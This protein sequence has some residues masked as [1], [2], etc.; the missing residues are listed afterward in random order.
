M[1]VDIV[2]TGIENLDVDTVTPE[3]HDVLSRLMP[4]DEEYDLY[5]KHNFD[6]GDGEKIPDEDVFMAKIC[7][8]RRLKQ[9]MRALEIAMSFQVCW[10]DSVGHFQVFLISSSFTSYQ[11]TFTW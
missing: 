2:V 4:T 8:I 10:K 11:V 6:L 7:R 1:P 5:R 9:K 3:V